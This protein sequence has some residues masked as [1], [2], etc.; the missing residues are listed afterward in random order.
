M[1]ALFL[2]IGTLRPICRPG[3]NQ[4]ELYSGHKRIHGIKFQS[5]VFPNG[6][7]GNLRGPYPGRRH[8]CYMLSESN[9]LNQLQLHIPTYCLYEDSAYPLRQQ[10]IN[11]YKG[12]NPTA[13][14][15]AFNKAISSVRQSVEWEFG[16]I[17]SLFAFLDFCKNLKLYL[18]PV[19][20]LYVIGALLKNC[21]T[22]LYESQ[23]SEFFNLSPPLLENYLYI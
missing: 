19:G 5:I 21:H 10:L 8:D 20:K 9:L 11:P 17:I 7:I 3:I 2:N 22:C 16:K 1:R 23:T 15:A 6:I 13:G 14:Q 4:R 18:Q 12:T